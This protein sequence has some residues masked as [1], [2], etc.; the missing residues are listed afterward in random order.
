MKLTAQ[1]IAAAVADPRTG[2][3]T[4]GKRMERLIVAYV[5]GNPHVIGRISEEAFRQDTRAATASQNEIWSLFLAGEI[6]VPAGQ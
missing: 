4:S 5:D 6:E 2:V 3:Y 1:Q